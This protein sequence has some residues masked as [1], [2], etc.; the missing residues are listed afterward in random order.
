[1]YAATEVL[2]LLVVRAQ[3]HPVVL[4][5]TFSCV[6]AKTETVRAIEGLR[7]WKSQTGNGTKA[8][9][10]RPFPSFSSSSASLMGLLFLA[11]DPRS[12]R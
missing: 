3:G 9:A 7:V 2:D 12:L 4:P 1:M 5:T 6:S 11:F 8:G 10:S